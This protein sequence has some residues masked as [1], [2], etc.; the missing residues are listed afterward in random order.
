MFRVNK[1]ENCT[2]KTTFPAANPRGKARA[3]IILLS[4]VIFLISQRLW[5]G[6]VFLTRFRFLRRPRYS[7]RG[8]D[9]KNHRA[10]CSEIFPGRF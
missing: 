6:N 2:S 7:G 10:V 9:F 4:L 5:F 3:V 1:V 8:D